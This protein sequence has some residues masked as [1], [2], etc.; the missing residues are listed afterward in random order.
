MMALPKITRTNVK[1][2]PKARPKTRPK[3]TPQKAAAASKA[4]RISEDQKWQAQDDL[5]TLARAEE[6]R[7]DPSRLGAAKREA[8]EQKKAL[9][10]IAE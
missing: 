6:I 3:S 9:E 8:T 5:R 7:T 1:T 10:K 4:E 2:A